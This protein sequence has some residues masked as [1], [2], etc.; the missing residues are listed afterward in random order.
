MPSRALLMKW[1]RRIARDE[2]GVTA[3]VMGV[4]I[5]ILMGGAAM[6]VDV[7]LW[8]ADQRN[9]QGAADSAAFSAAVDYKAGDGTAG[10]TAAARA[11]TAQYGLTNGSNGVTVT[12]NTPPKSGSHTATTGAVEVIV[13]KTESLFF[14]SLFKQSASISARAVSLAGAAGS[15]CGVLALD[16]SAS[17]TVSAT[18]LDLS[19]GATLDTSACEVAINA[20][21][22]DALYVTGGAKLLAKTLS[23]VGNYY[24]SNGG[25]VTVS[26]TT[27]TSAAATPNPYAGVSVPTFSGCAHNSA[28]YS[29]ST[30]LSPGVYCNG[31]SVSGGNVTL[32]AGVYIIDRGSFTLGGGATVTATSGVTIVLTSSTGSN[33]ATVSIGNGATLNITAPTSGQTAGMAF[34]QDPAAST[35]GSDNIAGGSSMSIVG[36]IYFPSQLVNFSNG[37]SNTASC[38]Q[39]I[40]Y[41]INY[42]GG[43]K[44]NDNCAGVGVKAIGGASS[45]LVE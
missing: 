5:S 37:S 14:S 11:V 33:Y 42:T 6:A 38:T 20:S 13:Q 17:T 22:A 23:I 34:F 39:L 24:T 3:V 12:V 2:A 44:F 26:G 4:G 10:V 16:A 28:S 25:T 30:L 15:N 18:D 8:Y 1:T 43:A 45:S 40:A 21:G 7:G 36:A 32:S 41:R 31:L 35:S 9:A 29:A 19:N 27:T